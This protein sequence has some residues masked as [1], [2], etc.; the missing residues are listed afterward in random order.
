MTLRKILLAVFTTLLLIGVLT[1]L[2]LAFQGADVKTAVR[3]VEEAKVGGVL[4]GDR[5]AKFV[6][7]S[8]RLC[9]ASVVSRFHGH[10]E[11]SCRD[12]QNEKRILDWR[13]NVIDG[14]VVPAN[15]AA[16]RLGK[17]EEPWPTN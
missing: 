14:M 9:E 5:M 7:Q 15:V 12:I 16:K 8:R 17:G 2:N 1:Y 10:M 3:L 6:P 11:V 4:L 13:V